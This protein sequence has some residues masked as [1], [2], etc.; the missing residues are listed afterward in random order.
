MKTNATIVCIVLFC[1]KSYSQMVFSENLNTYI[2]STKTIQGMISPFF[3]FKTEN[4]DVSTL[5]NLANINLL[6]KKITGCE[7]NQ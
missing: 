4:K 1:T 3:E 2:D 6:I 7:S 5:K